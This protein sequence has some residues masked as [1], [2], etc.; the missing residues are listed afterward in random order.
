M[1]RLTLLCAAMLLGGFVQLFAQEEPEPV[2]EKEPIT[3]ELIA[4][5][6][7]EPHIALNADSRNAAMAHNNFNGNEGM[8][9]GSSLYTHFEGDII[10]GLH[11]N[12]VNHWLAGSWPGIQGLYQNTW[13]T[14]NNWCDFATLSYQ[15][16]FGLKF[17]LGKECLAVATY[18]YDPYDYDCHY[19]LCSGMWNNLNAYQLGAKASYCFHENWEAGFQFSSS[20]FNKKPFS[21]G[22][23]SYSLFGFF[24][25]AEDD[26]TGFSFRVAL[27]MM[28]F[29]RKS[30]D[31]PDSRN[32]FLWMPS[33]G[34]RYDIE[35]FH[36]GIDAAARFAGTTTYFY[37]APGLLPGGVE[38]APVR[39]G[40]VILNLGYVI[41][42]DLEVF[43]T[44]G[45]EPNRGILSV[46]NYANY[47][48]DG[49]GELWPVSY[50]KNN[51]FC[52]GIG[53]YWYP[54]EDSKDLRV[55]VLF[56][57]SNYGRNLLAS[58]DSSLLP[59]D[60]LGIPRSVSSLAFNFGVT[61]CFRPLDL[62]GKKK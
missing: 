44:F 41:E 20:P 2:T 15:F 49:E 4:R 37:P 21:D 39:E 3:L 38:S 62:F 29:E 50:P 27:N 10:P 31:D 54:I 23:F 17:T 8:Y 1:K 52:G 40:N 7:V 26:D 59:T 33:L 14:D 22:L 13:T 46:L 18:E 9:S 60:A 11:F 61:Y 48:E 42:D 6:D 36:I 45:W 55:H 35:D 30:Q 28:Q 57:G 43:G 58:G 53:A 25:K 5:F 24:D 51:G 34:L 32:S 12:L 47:F 16:P 19:M 56:G